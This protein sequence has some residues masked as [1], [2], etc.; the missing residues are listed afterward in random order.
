MTKIKSPP[1]FISTYSKALA[2]FSA[3]V[4]VINFVAQRIDK[5]GQPNLEPSLAVYSLLCILM[6]IIIGYIGKKQNEFFLVMQNILVKNKSQDDIFDWFKFLS[7]ESLWAY[8]FP[9]V[10]GTSGIITMIIL[11]IPWTG[12]AYI[13]FIPTAILFLISLG[14]VSWCYLCILLWLWKISA[15]GTPVVEPFI[16]QEIKFK[17]LNGIFLNIFFTGVVIYTLAIVGVWIL[18]FGTWFLLST[19]LGQWW[20]FPLAIAVIFYF[21]LSQYFFHKIMQQIKYQRLQA[22]DILIDK[23]MKKW[24]R[25][26]DKNFSDFVAELIKLRGI[27]KEEAETPLNITTSITIIG[28]L[29]VPV[30]QSVI[31]LL[32]K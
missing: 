20:I 9:V 30:F 4:V 11:G 25:N 22:I 29:L 19:K 21:I 6:P 31:N 28:S 14:S 32:S 2:I 8:L 26:S 1:L 27:V 10:L 5:S 18:P 24:T 23:T 16:S 17:Q 7:W 15:K 13:T 3:F 12:L